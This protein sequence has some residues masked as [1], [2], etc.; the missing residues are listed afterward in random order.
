MRILVT[1]PTLGQ[2]PESLIMTI[3]SLKVF[4]P[5]ASIQ[6][7][8]PNAAL[9]GALL[10]GE[11]AEVSIIEDNDDQ[12]GS[13]LN[14][15]RDSDFD[16]YGW[17]NDDD[18]ALAGV[19]GAAKLVSKYKDTNLPIVVYG[20]LVVMTDNG[21]KKIP[22]PRRINKW[23]LSSGADYVPGLLTFINKASV[24]LLLSEDTNAPKLRNSF[25]YYWWLKLAKDGA[26]FIHSCSSH[27]IWRDHVGAR[28]RI[29]V[30]L[31]NS[32][33]KLI[34]NYFLPSILKFPLVY[35]ANAHLAKI[36]AK[37]LSRR[38]VR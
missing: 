24:R 23:L 30:P 6:I 33:T 9:L 34:K 11:Q 3:A 28:T 31:S 15:W 21:V 10:I 36:I 4:L 17:I 20:D 18:F 12:R 26:S 25:D 29:E 1:I 38:L 8:T 5:E 32:E 19:A 2:R 27:A 22:T 35:T 37:M 14:S 16:W 13:I 7:R